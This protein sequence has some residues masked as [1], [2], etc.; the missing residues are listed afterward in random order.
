M[1]GAWTPSVQ[2]RLL[3][4]LCEDGGEIVWRCLSTLSLQRRVVAYTQYSMYKVMVHAQ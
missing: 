4:A 2:E 3:G 1:E